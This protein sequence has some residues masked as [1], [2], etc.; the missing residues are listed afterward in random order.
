MKYLSTNIL[1][2]HQF[3]EF[4][5]CGTKIRISSQKNEFS[6]TSMKPKNVNSNVKII[7]IIKDMCVVHN[8]AIFLE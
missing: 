4:V 7:Y 6:H 5:V 2:G 8:A 3:W 1:K